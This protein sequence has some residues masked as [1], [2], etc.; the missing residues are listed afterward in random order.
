M[1]IDRPSDGQKL[2]FLAVVQSPKEHLCPFSP[3]A[4]REF[5]NAPVP[6]TIRLKWSFN[7][8]EDKSVIANTNKKPSAADVCP[9]DTDRTA[10]AKL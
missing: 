1:R 3:L 9:P 4:E 10:T 7:R 2:D 6:L 8:S 5:W